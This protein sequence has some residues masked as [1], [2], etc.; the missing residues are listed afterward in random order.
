MTA[1][2]K[3]GMTMA[4]DASLDTSEQPLHQPDAE[5]G[6]VDHRREV[7]GV[8]QRADQQHHQDP[9]LV[10]IQSAGQQIPFGDEPGHRRHADHAE[11]GHGK[12][13]EGQRH[14][15]AQAAH[16]GDVLLV[17]GDI[18]G[19]GAE[20]QG[21]LGKGVVGDVDDPA[22]DSGR[23]QQRHTQDDVGEL[24]DR[25]VGQPRLQ[26]VL[27]QGDDRGR[28][29]G[30]RNEVGRGDAQVEGASWCPHR[31]RRASRG[32]WRTRP[33]LTTATACSSALTGVGA[34]MAPGSQLWNGMTPFLAK[35]RMQQ[36]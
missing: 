28:Q 6:L 25:G 19:A 24:A 33:T 2:I 23:G 12:G 16:L 11:G 9:D 7:G 17:R 26:V 14:D 4:G 13:A 32:W 5:K 3:S 15:P 30:E 29:N 18:D 1:V 8:E 10:G 31:R 36:T 27:A 21:D 22:L 34:T 35:P 20:E